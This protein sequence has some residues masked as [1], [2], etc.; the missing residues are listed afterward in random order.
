M[1]KDVNVFIKNFPNTKE[2]EAITENPDGTY[3][4]FLNARMSYE[5]QLEAYQHAL[6]HIQNNDF[7][8]LDVQQIEA[9]A[10]ADPANDEHPTPA[11]PRKKK[12]RRR[13]RYGQYEKQRQ[14]LA[15]FGID[16][17]SQHEA[18]WLDP[19]YRF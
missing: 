3:T 8:K 18:R 7:Q 13:S 12:R 1:T 11:I 6:E 14:A 16:V 15:A 10:H 2:A 5:R 17:W 19:D 9:I 4:I